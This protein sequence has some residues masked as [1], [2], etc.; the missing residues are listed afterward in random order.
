MHE[1]LCPTCNT[2]GQYDLADYLLFCTFCSTTFKVDLETGKK[3]IYGD[4]YIVANTIDARRAKELVLEW[5]RRLH[6]KPGSADKEHVIIDIHGLSLPFWVVSTEVH[7]LWKGLVRRHKRSQLEHVP[8]SE[9]LMENGQ[10]RR[11]YRWAIS[12]RKNICESWGMIRL[13]EPKESVGVD[14]DGF[15]LDST[16]SRGRIDENSSDKSVYEVR[17]FFEFKYSNGLP[18]IGV[19][20]NEQDALHR[21]QTHL[22]QY[23]YR[24]AQLNVDYLIECRTE[25]DIAG[26]QLIHLP[27]WFARYVYQPRS[28][29]RHVYKPAEKNA[30]LDGFGTGLLKGE[31]ALVRNDKIWIN[32]I[33]CGIA[34]LFMLIMG[35]VWHPAFFLVAFFGV[36][37]TVASMLI[38]GSKSQKEEIGAKDPGLSGN[39]KVAT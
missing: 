9:Y 15:P 37:V 22:Q 30:I 28:A 6:H 12:G 19:Q 17:E 33:I 36:C 25:V 13:H 21:A 1:L 10:F 38:A 29:L 16:F 2:A 8:G 23:H 24:L 27:F 26:I 34:T 20:V 14:W 39:Q 7:T 35:A 32:S 31:L 3:E 11:S 4:H 5:L 18:I